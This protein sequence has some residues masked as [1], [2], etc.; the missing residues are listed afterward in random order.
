MG[1]WYKS[2]RYHIVMSRNW[3]YVAVALLPLCSCSLKEE[4]DEC[5]CIVSLSLDPAL[6]GNV[7]F[8]AVNDDGYSFRRDDVLS[9]EEGGTVEYEIVRG[10]NILYMY[11][12]NLVSDGPL[13]RYRN[14]VQADSVYAWNS[15]LLNTNMEM[16]S[17]SPEFKKQFAT[18][19]LS[20]I[21]R[22]KSVFKIIVTGGV[23]G[24]DL[25]TMKP[26]AGEFACRADKIDDWYYVFRL[27]RQFADE[28]LASEPL[29]IEVYSESG[30]AASCPLG[31]AISATGYD[32][33]DESLSDIYVDMDIDLVNVSIDVGNWEDGGEHS[34]KI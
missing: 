27:P 31:E 19:Y 29:K 3:I 10:N 5:P 12:G 16:L 18:V 21:S 26:L 23:N 14:G 4:R 13:I 30:L 6:E 9:D 20:I 34:F 24:L 17:I 22:N 8:G 25:R 1:K 7:V 33:E 32:W 28:R 2:S 15:G 11:Q